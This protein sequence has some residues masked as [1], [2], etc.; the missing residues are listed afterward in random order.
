MGSRA[1][2]ENGQVFCG[3]PARCFKST[4]AIKEEFNRHYW[5]IDYQR[6]RFERITE[7]H[8]NEKKSRDYWLID[9]K[10]F[11]ITHSAISCVNQ[12]KTAKS[13]RFKSNYHFSLKDMLDRFLWQICSSYIGYILF[14][15]TKMILQLLPVLVVILSAYN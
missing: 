4:R 10:R 7:K 2:S 8:C 12:C 3:S 6:R 11:I 14:E 9:L 15:L 13:E 5:K 1:I